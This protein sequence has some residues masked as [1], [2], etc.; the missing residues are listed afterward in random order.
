MRGRFWISTVTRR[1]G[2]V[3]TD[4]SLKVYGEVELNA[5]SRSTDDNVDWAHYTP[6][7]KLTMTVGPEARE[8][9]EAHQGEDVYLD[10][11]PIP[12]GE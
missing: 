10:L 9:F 12:K 11:T 2:S 1:V 5:V 4:G 3:N 6:V 7:G 8:W